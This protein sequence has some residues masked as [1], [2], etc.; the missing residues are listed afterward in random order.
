MGGGGAPDPPPPA[1]AAADP[2][3]ADPAALRLR[4]ALSALAARTT[5]ASAATMHNTPKVTGT[6]STRKSML[7]SPSP[8]VC[9]SEV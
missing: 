8:C 5:H 1:A 2:A 9:L 6:M 3:A 4:A 7:T